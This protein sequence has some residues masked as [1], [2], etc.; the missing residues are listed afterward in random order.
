VTWARRERAG[1]TLETHLILVAAQV[2]FGSLAVAGRLAMPHIPANAI[3]LTRLF[4]GFVVFTLLARAQRAPAIARADALAVAGCAVLGVVLNMVFF[5]NGLAR[6]TATNA[7]VLGS[8]IPVFTALFALA[9]GREAFRRRRFAGIAVA[10]AG[11]MVL[12]GAWNVSGDREHMVGNVM[13][14]INAASYGLYLVVVRP[15]AQRY[16][17]AALASGVF[18]VGLIIVFPIAI[19]DWVRLAPTLTARDVGLLGFIVAVPTVGAYLFTQLALQ[20]AESSLVASYIYLQPVVAAI[21][22]ILILGERPGPQVGIAAAL[23]FL[24]VWISSGTKAPA[25]APRSSPD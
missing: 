2:C 16:R 8:T 4:G 9:L 19:G 24:G 1:A 13:V 14:L 5:L 21:G 25:P 22:A 3:V 10:L 20:R 15:Y 6:S 17:P 18:L 11:A 12:V 23:I 7:T